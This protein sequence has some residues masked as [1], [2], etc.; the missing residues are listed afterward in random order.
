MKVTFVEKDGEMTVCQWPEV[1]KVATP[2]AL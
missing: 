1:S 2:F